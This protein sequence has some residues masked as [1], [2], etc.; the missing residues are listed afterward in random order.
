MRRCSRLRWTL[1]YVESADDLLQV[2]G[3]ARH[4]DARVRIAAARALARIGSRAELAVLLELLRDSQW[5]VRYHAAHA[6]T[7]LHGMDAAEIETLQRL[8][9]DPFAADSLAQALAD[10]ASAA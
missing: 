4:G 6:V 2:R 8:A 3:A 7:A 5:W 10:R 9:A 1:D